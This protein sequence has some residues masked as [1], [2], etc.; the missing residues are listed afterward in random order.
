[1]LNTGPLFEFTHWWGNSW[2]NRN[3]RKFVWFELG[4]LKTEMILLHDSI[5]VD[6]QHMFGGLHLSWKRNYVRSAS[7]SGSLTVIHSLVKSFKSA[8]LICY[9]PP[10]PASTS[11]WNSSFHLF[12]PRPWNISVLHS[13]MLTLFA[14]RIKRG[15]DTRWYYVPLQLPS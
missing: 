15:G 2:Q 3:W 5:Q 10:L 13:R 11:F 7:S 1:M 8:C 12:H 9:C 4:C 14:F 6:I